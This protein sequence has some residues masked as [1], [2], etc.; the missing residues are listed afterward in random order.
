MAQFA[1]E[2]IIER[3]KK[4][5]EKYHLFYDRWFRESELR[6]KDEDKKLLSLLKNKNLI[7]KKD[8]A[9]WFKSSR[10]CDEK[11]RVLVTGDGEP[12]YFLIDIAYHQNKYERGFDFLYNFWG[13]DHHGYIDRMKAAMIALGHAKDS[14]DVGIIQQ[15]NLLR[16]GK[17]V[18]MSKRAGE[19]VEMDELIDEVGVDVSRFFFADRRIS[20]PMDFDIDLA[21]KESDENPVY[22]VQY[23]HARICSI[24]R[25]AEEQGVCIPDTADLSV[26]E[27]DEEMAVIK[28][29]LEFPEVISKATQFFEP[30]RLTSYLRDVATVFH[31]FYHNHRV[32][33]DDTKLTAAR[34]LLTKAT[35][36]VLANG[37]KILG[38]SAPERM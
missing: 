27:A 12:T 24:L 29:L 17:V 25:F 18:K 4:S 26:L 1:S 9:T 28:K 32:V 7:Y 37:F 8:G 36:Q 31:R 35:K 34:L 23:A 2:R 13:P 11:D 38:I 22:Y 5:M 33:T 10:F 19:I 30:H 20:T 14:F 21:K 6:K 16:G 15:V 3:Q